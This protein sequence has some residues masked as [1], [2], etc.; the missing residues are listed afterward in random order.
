M[1][2]GL[3]SQEFLN[4]NMLEVWD[5]LKAVNADHLRRV[6]ESDSL[7]SFQARQIGEDAHNAYSGLQSYREALIAQ[8]TVEI[9]YRLLP[10]VESMDLSSRED[11]ELVLDQG[12]DISQEV[13]FGA[14]SF[15]SSVNDREFDLTWDGIKFTIEPD[16]TM[17]EIQANFDNLEHIA[18][19][20][21]IS[22]EPPRG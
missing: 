22:L 3:T 12:L 21:H 2:E 19:L 13:A 7:A 16:Q 8:R 4:Q 10:Q 1:A 9:A 6:A 18:R 11:L 17:E 15:V 20:G 14:V 5:K